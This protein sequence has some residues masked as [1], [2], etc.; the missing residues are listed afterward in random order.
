MAVLHCLKAIFRSDIRC[1]QMCLYLVFILSFPAW[2]WFPGTKV[3]MDSGSN[4]ELHPGPIDGSVLTLQYDHRST[5]MW[6]GQDFE[7]LTCRR[8]NGAFWLL[9]ALDPRIQP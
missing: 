1:L 2:G 8:C 3:L 4:H 6:C 9:G 5:A 7:P